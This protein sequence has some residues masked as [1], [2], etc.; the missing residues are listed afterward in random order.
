MMKLLK[1]NI[2]VNIPDLGLGFLH[3]THKAQANQTK[4]NQ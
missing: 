3:I 4:P 1:E 2:G